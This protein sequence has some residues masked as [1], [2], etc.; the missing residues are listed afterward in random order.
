MENNCKQKILIPIERLARS[1]KLENVVQE[2]TNQCGL[3]SLA[4]E[5][6]VDKSAISRFRSGEGALSM[7]AVQKILDHAGV[8]I[9]SKERYTAMLSSVVLFSDLVKEAIGE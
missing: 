8:M 4:E 7:A 5:I 1:S 9:V 3:T 6:G 2:V